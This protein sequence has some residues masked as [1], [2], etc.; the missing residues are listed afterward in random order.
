MGPDFGG[1]LD[2]RVGSTTNSV[3]RNFL[4]DGAYVTDPVLAYGAAI[5]T[6]G[7]SERRGAATTF[8]H[9][10][11]KNADAQSRTTQ[12][13]AATR[14]YD[15]FGNL[16]SSAGTW[17]GP[18]GYGG[19]FGYQEDATGLRLIGKRSYDSSTGRFL[20][21]DPVRDGRNWYVYCGNDPISF[22]DFAGER[23]V[24]VQLG[25]GGIIPF[26][27]GSASISIG[28]DL[29]NGHI[30]VQGQVG[31]GVGMGLSGGPGLT[32]NYDH[33]GTING[34]GEGGWGERS[35]SNALGIAVLAVQAELALD[36][37]GNVTGGGA[38]AGLGTDHG[39]GAG[40]YYEKRATWTYDLTQALIDTWDGIKD[41]WEEHI[42]PKW[43]VRP[44]D[45]LIAL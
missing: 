23:A 24:W 15:A 6:P 22:Y 43:P 7:V 41:F 34:N 14:Q 8:L 9:P 39:E 31:G 4:R 5:Y 21:R 44:E 40:V 10:G 35:T 13:V 19:S 30:G 29:D 16:A 20:T 2:I 11:L 26:L 33:T 36:D 37:A 3:S 27:S 45:W 28:V 38:G 18:F 25:I 32:G 17:N 1:G 12:T 42:I